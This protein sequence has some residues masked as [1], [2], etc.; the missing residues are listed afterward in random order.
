MA[1]SKQFWK[2]IGKINPVGRPTKFATPEELLSK[3]QEYFNYIDGNP[4]YKNE[5]IKKPYRDTTGNWVTIT[6]I[7]TARPYTIEGLCL[8]LGVNKMYFNEF[9]EGLRKKDDDLSVMFSG[10]C[11]RVRHIIFMQ[12]FEGAAVGAFSASIIARELG[13]V[14]KQETRN[15]DKDGNDISTTTIHVT[16]VDK[17]PPI[18]ETEE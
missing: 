11:S 15:V 7:P 8:W 5:Q 1:Q 16:T 3:C 10:I 12:K 9:E 17:A 6:R 18:S 2:E 14:D 4:W 13:L